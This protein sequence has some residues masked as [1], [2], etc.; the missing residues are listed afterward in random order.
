MF[1][2]ELKRAFSS[3]GML[4]VVLFSILLSVAVLKGSLAMQKEYEAIIIRVGTEKVEDHTT[5]YPDTVFERCLTGN[6][7][8]PYGGIYYMLFPIL[9]VLPFGT[10]YARD[11]ELNYTR[12]ILTRQ[13][14]S[15]YLLA[16]YLA[17]FVS[18]AAASVMPMLL[19]LIVTMPYFPCIP[20]AMTSFQSGIVDRQI[21]SE[22]Y[23]IHP[24]IYFGLFLVL[25][26]A[27]GGLLAG[28][29]LAVSCFITKP[30]AVLFMPFLVYNAVNYAL[31]SPAKQAYSLAQIID[32]KSK[33]T[34]VTLPLAVKLIGGGILLSLVCYYAIAQKRERIR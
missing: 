3:K 34:L 16:K 31:A 32:P 30:I 7:F 9:A 23:F 1:S 25:G 27:A 2:M 21:F 12:N 28:S 15:R 19:S 24:W 13:K 22:Y 6:T 11:E 4:I 17:A 26:L 10:S 18:G 29:A 33:A 14:K 20:P 5:Y 8:L